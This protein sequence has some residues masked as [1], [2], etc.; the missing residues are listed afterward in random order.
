[1][2]LTTLTERRERGDM[3][4]TFKI[5]NGFNKVDKTKWFL[6][7]DGTNS[8]SMRVT[9]SVSNGVQQEKKNVLFKQTV[10]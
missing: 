7:R 10:R 5:I 6:F 9:V 8:R 2:G 3:I 4:E 1:M